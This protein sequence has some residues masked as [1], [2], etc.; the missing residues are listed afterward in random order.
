M[1]KIMLLGGSRYLVPVIKKAYKLGL[2]VIIYQIN[3]FMDT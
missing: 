1:K 3:I 2:Y